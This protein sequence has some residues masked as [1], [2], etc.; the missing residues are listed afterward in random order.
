MGLVLLIPLIGLLMVIGYAKFDGR[1]LFRQSRIGRNEVVFTIVKLRSMEVGAT[2]IDTHLVDYNAV[3][4]YGRFLRRNKLDEL[5]QLWNVL[6]GEMS[7]VGPRP[8]LSSQ[9]LLIDLRKKEEI[10]EMRPGITG[11]AQLKSID[12]SDPAKLVR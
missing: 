8:C 9:T 11:L 6:R 1:P 4:A 2:E 10:F 7:L 12:M 5:P 3:T